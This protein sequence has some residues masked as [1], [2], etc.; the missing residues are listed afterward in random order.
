MEA[1]RDT[2]T[3][4]ECLTAPPG[5]HSLAILPAEFRSGESQQGIERERRML[6]RHRHPVSRKGWDQPVRVAQTGARFGSLGW[7][8]GHGRYRAPAP[9]DD[10]FVIDTLKQCLETTMRQIIED[11]GLART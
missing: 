4:P 11:Q 7:L 10:S 9:G 5:D 3:P 6:Q 1:A 8:V 2:Q